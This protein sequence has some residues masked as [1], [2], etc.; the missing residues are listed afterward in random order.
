MNKSFLKGVTLC[1]VIG[2]MFALLLAGCG[3]EAGPGE[4][5]EYKLSAIFAGSIQDADYVS[6][7]YLSINDVAEQYGID[8]A[9]SEQ[10]AVPDVERVMRE[11][12][13]GGYNIIWVHGNQFNSAALEIADEFPDVSFIIEVDAT[14]D[15]LKPNFWYMDRNFHTGFY[16]LGALAGLTTE[17]GNIGYV[18]G[19]ELPFARA[20]L[21]AIQQALDDL[22]EDAKI[23]YS[24]VGDFGDPV[25]SR[26]TAESLI[27]AGCDVLISSVNL[28]NYGVF[29]AVEKA[30][31]KVYVT[32][33][34]TDKREHAPDNYLTTDMFD[35]SKPMIEIVGNIVE[36]D[37]GGLMYLE[38][39]KDKAR[40]TQFPINLVSE[41]V[42]QKVMQIADDVETGNITVVH[43]FEE[44]NVK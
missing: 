34:Y 30:D 14:P 12:I 3:P 25:K 22:G 1:V 13:D 7:G 29:T 37:K 39:G 15:E 31:R 19:L 4:E 9:Y 28:G 11:Y 5:V 21:N 10:V 24:F 41:E 43:N 36:G 20:E 2:M 40:T 33:K 6:L 18:G 23:H 17:T 44:I 8:I 27:G 32:T 16:V 42:N 38:Y 35:F 26:T